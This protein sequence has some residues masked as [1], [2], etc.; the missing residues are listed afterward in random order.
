V[1]DGG[2]H[3]HLA[4]PIATG[5][6]DRCL[7]HVE[8]EIL[9]RLLLFHGSRSLLRL[10]VRRFQKYRKGRTFNMRWATKTSC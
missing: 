1:E 4:L 3:D 10:G 5:G 2:P 9:N 7:M 8:R 6:H